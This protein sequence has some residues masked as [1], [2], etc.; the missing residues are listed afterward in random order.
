MLH[1]ATISGG[2]KDSIM[3]YLL[4]KADALITATDEVR[5]FKVV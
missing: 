5:L 4:L 2:A 3:R 1:W